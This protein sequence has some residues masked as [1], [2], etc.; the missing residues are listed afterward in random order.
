MLDIVMTDDNRRMTAKVS[1]DIDAAQRKALK[2]GL[3]EK[4]QEFK[5][6][7][8]EIDC[9]ALDYIDSTG[10]GVLVSALRPVK[11]YGGEI[12]ITK[13]KPFLMK[14]FRITGLDDIFVLE[15]Q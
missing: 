11:E 6:E 5:P 14:I 9:G 10:L 13:L 3:E 7:T 1:G 2:A 4:I 15:E 12:R 8:V